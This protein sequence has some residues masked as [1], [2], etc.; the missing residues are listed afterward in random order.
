MYSQTVFQ[1]SEIQGVRSAW[2]CDV[3]RMMLSI[4]GGNKR[5]HVRF[6]GWQEPGR[7]ERCQ[8]SGGSR[9]P[10]SEMTQS[11][12]GGFVTSQ[13]KNRNFFLDLFTSSFSEKLFQMLN[14]FGSLLIFFL[15]WQSMWLVIFSTKTSIKLVSQINVLKVTLK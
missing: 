12:Y 1:K 7:R 10:A 13:W 11:Y 14:R 8:E 2:S 15:L 4:P 3:S 9:E 5:E 6:K